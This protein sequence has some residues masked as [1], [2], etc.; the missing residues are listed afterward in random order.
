[1]LKFILCRAFSWTQKAPLIHLSFAS[2][3]K[4]KRDLLSPILRFW[5]PMF[6]WAREGTL[7]GGAKGAPF[8]HVGQDRGTGQ[9]LGDCDNGHPTPPPPFFLL[10]LPPLFSPTLPAA[11]A[12]GRK[13]RRGRETFVT[14]P[15]P[16]LPGEEDR[17]IRQQATR[18]TDRPPL[19][20]HM[21]QDTGE[22]HL[23]IDRRKS[24]TAAFPSTF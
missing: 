1:M 8:G 11:A 3:E 22:S 14:V 10:L 17:F 19:Y 18:K 21:L 12:G 15:P 7:L 24:T 16:L 4:R 20:A 2:S 9:E 5:A 6:F 23:S 13:R